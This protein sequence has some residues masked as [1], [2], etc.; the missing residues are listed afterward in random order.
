MVTLRFFV[1]LF[2]SATGQSKI[3]CTKNH[4]LLLCRGKRGDRQLGVAG[5]RLTTDR[6]PMS[7]E[8]PAQLQLAGEGQSSFGGPAP[9]RIVVHP[10][11]TVV[12]ESQPVV[13]N[14][15]FRVT[16]ANESGG[17]VLRW[18]K[19]GKV[20]RRWDNLAE[21]TTVPT[22]DA[23]VGAT[24]SSSMFRDDGKHGGIMTPSTLSMQ[25]FQLGIDCKTL[26]KPVEFKQR[27]VIKAINFSIMNLIII[28]IL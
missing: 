8:A 22:D 7:D 20:I 15:G 14:C 18:R 19:D 5:D 10:V 28:Q 21:A 6:P 25:S 4:N 2:L 3:D 17:F 16:A 27:N 13:F 26:G 24:E 23:M 11:T 12:N 1:L 9:V